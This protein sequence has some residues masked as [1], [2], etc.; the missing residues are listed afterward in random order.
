MSKVQLLQNQ[1]LY[2]GKYFFYFLK[3]LELIASQIICL[4]GLSL[5]YSIVTKKD[6]YV[7]LFVKSGILLQPTIHSLQK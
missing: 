7:K 6:C 5:Y 1:I 4:P 2:Q 3:Q